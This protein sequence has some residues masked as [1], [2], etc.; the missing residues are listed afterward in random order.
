MKN[1]KTTYV[2]IIVLLILLGIFFIE[3]IKTNKELDNA[4]EKYAIEILR[5]QSL[6]DSIKNKNGEIVKLQ[7]AVVF[8]DKKLLSKYADSV[9]ALRK[10]DA[11]KYKETLAYYQNYINTYLPDTIYSEVFD[12]TEAKPVSD[13]PEI[14]YYIDNSISVPRQFNIDSTHFKLSGLI[15][16]TGVGITSLSLP[17]TIS[18]RFIEKKNGFFKP[19]TI[20][21]QLTNTNPYITI[22]GSKS[23]I[24]KEPKKK[25][26]GKV[27]KIVGLVGIGFLTSQL[28]K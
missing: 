13:N 12:T 25:F 23:A 18:G 1:I 3:S 11:K 6:L 2:I 4:K 21:Y 7:D 20:E 24:Y 10:K 5:S 14:Q 15:N 22:Q 17:D 9:F 16:K 27:G 28:I 19:N 26:W 8:V